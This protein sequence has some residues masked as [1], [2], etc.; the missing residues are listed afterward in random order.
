[1]DGC[2]LEPGKGL[3]KNQPRVQALL[4]RDIRRA[5]SRS[6]RPSVRAG[7]RS[8]FSARKTC[9]TFA[10]AHAQNDF[11]ELNERFVP[12]RSAGG[13]Y[14]CGCQGHG[15]RALAYLPS[16]HETIRTPAKAFELEIELCGK[17]ASYLV[18]SERRRPEVRVSANR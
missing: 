1:M 8:T 5:F 4:R 18:G 16:P 17:P 12:R 11:C 2:N 6:E 15:R 3:R 14:L 13:L 10:V 7:L 9:G